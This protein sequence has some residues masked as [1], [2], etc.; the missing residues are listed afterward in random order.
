[1]TFLELRTEL[2]A[3]GFDYLSATRLGYLLNRV[4]LELAEEEDWPWLEATATGAP[5]LAIT[6]LR[7]IESV[8]N[9]TNQA[10]LTPLDRRLITDMDYTLATTGT[11]SYYYTT[12]TTTVAVYPA[13]TGV[14]LSVRYWKVPTALSADGDTPA[15]PARFH[16]LLVDGAAAYAYLDTDNFEGSQTAL[17]FFNDGKARM[18]DSLLNQQHDR[19]D[20]SIVIVG[21]SEDW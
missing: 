15:L 17:G 5:P 18:R 3:R 10:K 21:G 7:T 13:N 11:P 20:D 9:T 12:G 2:K 1:M 4:Y 6:D 16:H 19:T 14:S 8:I